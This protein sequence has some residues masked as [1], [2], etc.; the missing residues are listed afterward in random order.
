ML[1]AGRSLVPDMTRSM[2]FFFPIYLIVPAALGPGVYLSFN[3]NKY[4]KQRKT[5]FWGVKRGCRVRLTISPPSVNRLSRYHGILN[6]S[7]SYRPVRPV[8]GIALLKLGHKNMAVVQAADVMNDVSL[9]E[10]VNIR[11]SLT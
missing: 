5:C 3:R 6:I 2:N 10:N 8:T 7:Q 9:L 1:Q 11:P 4:R